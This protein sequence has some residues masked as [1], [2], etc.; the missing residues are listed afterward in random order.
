MELNY[1]QILE[2]QQKI[3]S[4]S[5]NKLWIILFRRAMIKLSCMLANEFNAKALITGENIG[6]VSSQTLSNIQAISLLVQIRT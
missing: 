6:Q 4:K 5:P 1:N 2:I 3:M